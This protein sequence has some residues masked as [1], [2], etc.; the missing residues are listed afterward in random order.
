M[1]HTNLHELQHSKYV[2]TYNLL[3]R[4]VHGHIENAKLFI[5]PYNFIRLSNRNEQF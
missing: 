5:S 3:K 4:H 2:H 1:N